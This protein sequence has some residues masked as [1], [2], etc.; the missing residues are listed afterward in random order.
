MVCRMEYGA[1]M[2]RHQ[3]EIFQSREEALQYLALQN[4]ISLSYKRI[5]R[6]LFYQTIRDAHAYATNYTN[7]F[8]TCGGNR[9]FDAEAAKK[10][11]YDRIVAWV[12]TP[13]FE[14]IA[15]YL[16]YDAAN[17]RKTI[18]DLLEGRNLAEIEPLINNLKHEGRIYGFR[19]PSPK[20]KDK[21]K[22]GSD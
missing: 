17:A 6:E 2:E 10:R 7:R 8:K 13:L 20:E 9:S 19:G 12:D 22:E 16:Q 1:T 4:A 21:S 11:A 14:T 3:G 15:K 18:L 5:A